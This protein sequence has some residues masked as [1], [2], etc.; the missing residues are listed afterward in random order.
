MAGAERRQVKMALRNNLA[1]FDTHL[2]AYVF[3]CPMISFKNQNLKLEA[4]SACLSNASPCAGPGA[5]LILAPPCASWC[6]VSR[7]TTWRTRLNP[8]GLQYEFVKLANL[9]IGRLLESTAGIRAI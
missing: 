8:L 7:G 2:Q 4:N 9:T 1:N 5:L 6:R 3:P